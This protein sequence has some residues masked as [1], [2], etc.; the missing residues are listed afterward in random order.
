MCS[1]EKLFPSLEI[2]GG[3]IGM[4]ILIYIDSSTKRTNK[5]N[6]YGES[7]AAWGL[8]NN[9]S[10]PY[11]C[12]INYFK[13][14]GP[15][16]T[17]YQGVIRALEQ[18]LDFCW[19]DHVIVCGDCIPVI[20]QLTGERFVNVMRS[21]YSQTQALIKKYRGKN[22]IVN[23]QYINENDNKYKKIDQLSKLSRDFIKN[24]VA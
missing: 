8:W 1:V 10:G 21:E 18:C 19:E 9:N 12:G 22:N 23:F 2:G 20:E 17:F 13:Y 3:N 4:S 14:G 5:D 6:K 15:N 7:I 11:R 24:I 16:K